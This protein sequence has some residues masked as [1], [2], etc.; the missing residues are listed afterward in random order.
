MRICLQVLVLDR[1]DDPVTPLL[2]QWTFQAMVHE[3]LGLHDNR[4]DLHSVPGV[5][6]VLSEPLQAQELGSL[7]ACCVMT[8]DMCMALSMALWSVQAAEQ[9]CRTACTSKCDHHIRLYVHGVQVKDDFK[10]IVLSSRQDDFYKRHMYSN[11]GDLGTA[12]QVTCPKSPHLHSGHK[13]SESE[14]A[15]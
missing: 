3:L 4:V 9:V 14:Q 7:H 8:T 15:C 13:R 2:L 1:K 11:F 12:V 5:R 10:E 6:I